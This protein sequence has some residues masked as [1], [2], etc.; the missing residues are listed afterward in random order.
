MLSI[1][2]RLVLVTKC[3]YYA[4]SDYDYKQFIPLKQIRHSQ[5]EGY[6][7]RIVFYLQGSR[8]GHILFSVNDHPNYERDYVYEFGK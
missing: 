6:L 7:A 8:D 4:I 1:I 3:N 2:L 5:P